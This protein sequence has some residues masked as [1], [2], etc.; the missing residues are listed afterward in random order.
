[1]E[2]SSSSDA[3]D[4]RQKQDD[5]TARSRGQ[6]SKTVGREVFFGLEM[7]VNDGTLISH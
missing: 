2:L 5:Q 4:V 1:M 3:F 6:V 7:M